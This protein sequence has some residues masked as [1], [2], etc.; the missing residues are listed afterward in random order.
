VEKRRGRATCSVEPCWG[1]EAMDIHSTYYIVVAH[2]YTQ[3]PRQIESGWE[4]E[5]RERES[6]SMAR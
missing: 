2:T 1:V 5:K 3:T 4:G 6:E